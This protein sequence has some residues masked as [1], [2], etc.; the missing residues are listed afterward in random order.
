MRPSCFQ[1]SVSVVCMLMTLLVCAHSAAAAESFAKKPAK[2]VFL[3]IG[4]GMGLPQKQA[5]EAFTGRQLV[6]DSFPV[7]GITTTPAA[8]RFIVDSA[9]AATAMSTGQLTDVGM[10]GMAPDKTKVKTIAEMAREKGMKVGIVSSV[11]IDHATPAAFYAHEESRNLYH[12]IDHALASSGFD[13][14]AGGGIKD[15]EGK[16][17]GVEPRGNAMDAIKNAGY[18][19]VTDRDEFLKL[20]RKD[21][22]V[23]AYNSWLQ[24]SGALPYAMD[25][26]PG[27]DITLAEFTA[28]G[29]DLLDNSKGFFMM[30]EGGKID[31]ACHANDAKAAIMDTVAFDEA[32]AEAVRFYKKHPDETLIVVTGDHECGGM[33]LGLAGTAYES[34]FDVLK[35]QYVSFQYFA[36]DV[37]KL[38][39]KEHQ[40]SLAFN[41]LKPTITHYFGLQFAG[42]HADPM[43]VQPHELAQLQD[44]FV[45]SVAGD[46]MKLNDPVSVNLYGG[47]DPLIVTIT[48]LLNNKAGLA[49]TSF[50]HTAVP[51]GTTAVGR[52]ADLF[53]GSYHQTAIAKKIM[54]AMGVKPHVYVAAN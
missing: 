29:I 9:A 49:W 23:F 53:G 37:L 21:R 31:W 19:V 14:F 38:F 25:S 22:K 10:I 33:T 3:F 26:R 44:A 48:H 51:V 13:Y 34:D 40:G 36:D 41:D 27:K 16:R 50:S 6:L 46:S 2:Y 20:N 54:T 18:K 52:G 12:Y 17:K 47:Y 4:D 28:K 30:V 24:D 39:K 35:K 1:R 8:N 43:Y 32:V 42:D 7:H 5:T 11:S 45:K 15:P